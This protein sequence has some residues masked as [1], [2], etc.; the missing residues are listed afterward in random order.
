MLF[1]LAPLLHTVYYSLFSWDGLTGKAGSGLANYSEAIR[2]HVLL[3]RSSTP[4][5]LI[6]FYAVIPVMLGLLLTAALTRSRCAASGSSGR[7]SSCR[8]SSPAS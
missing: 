1:T 5:I 4:A 3:T 2:D 8:S 7:R 6:V